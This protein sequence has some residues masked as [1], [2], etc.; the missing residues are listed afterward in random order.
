MRG[1]VSK[2]PQDIFVGSLLWLNS[3]SVRGSIG[4]S[5]L[6]LGAFLLK[7]ID[8]FAGLGGFNLALRRQGLECVFA[9]EKDPVLR[10][11]Y[12]RNHGLRAHGDI[13]AIPSSLVPEHDVL[14]A[15]F[16]C[17]P[18][19]K[20]G[21]Q[22]GFDHPVWGRL[23][24][25]VLRILAHHRPGFFILENVPNLEKHNSGETFRDIR[26]RLTALDYEVGWRRLSPHHF[27]IPQIRDRLFIVGALGGLRAFSWPEPEPAPDR[28]PA[29]SPF[30]ECMPPDARPVPARV[31]HCLDV[32]QDFLSQ[33][34][35]SVE[36]PWYP[37]WSMEWGATYPYEETTPHTLGPKEARDL[38][39]KFRS[40]F[41][42]R[43]AAQAH[44]NA[45]LLCAREPG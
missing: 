19:S 13:T 31:D 6:Y 2:R 39:G 45:S 22:A 3:R 32:W 41:V 15:G 14:C 1:T 16:P 42:K 5:L 25:E 30:I 10:D 23:F 24:D 11:L 4:A 37:L 18:F 12:S 9:S 34:P 17:Q 28:V 27:G 29:G 26:E 40:S 7:F 20:A 43:A 35:E 8:L 36:L 38:S 21:S 44:G 33:M